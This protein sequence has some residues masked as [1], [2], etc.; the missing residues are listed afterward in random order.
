MQ[1]LCASCGSPFE[2][3]RPQAKYCGATCRV[4]GN[5][6]AAASGGATNSSPPAVLPSAGGDLVSAVTAELV[7]ADRQDSALGVQAIALAR[8]MQQFD[9]GGG[10]ASL[11]KEL[12]AVMASA[13]ANAQVA[14]DPLD[15]L[16]ARRNAKRTAAS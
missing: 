6:A 15:E 5:R 4:R 1:R 3:K 12:R 16:R 11:S 10:L 7:A 9:T 2:A 13:L 8:R 14:A